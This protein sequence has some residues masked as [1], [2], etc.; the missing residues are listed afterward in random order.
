MGNA[1]KMLAVLGSARRGGNTETLMREAMR[2]AGAGE[3]TEV[4]VLSEMN[5]NDCQGCGGCRLDGSDGCI[6]DDDMQGLYREMKEADLIILGSPIY[7]GEL[8]G[9]MKSFMDRWY[10]LRD[11]KRGLRIAP[12]K[13]VLF[14]I[15]QGAVE[16]DRYKDVVRR[17]EKVLASYE[18][19]P[20]MLV[21]PGIE[22]KGTVNGRPELLLKAFEA[23]ERLS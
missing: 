2:G 5:V 6:F 4:R 21:A 12:G 7:Y 22:K 11:G 13:K 3:N 23:G 20:V 1:L 19:K 10:A 16:E 9:R 14:I 18:M 15:T 8:T 17:V